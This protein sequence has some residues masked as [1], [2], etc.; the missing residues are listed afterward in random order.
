[1]GVI[2]SNLYVASINVAPT[3]LS[4]DTTYVALNNPPGSGVALKV[5][6]IAPQA[7]FSGTNAATRSFFAVQKTASVATGGAAITPTHVR[8]PI[9][10]SLAD[11]RFSNAGLTIVSSALNRFFF[12]AVPSQNAAV[13]GARR[14][15]SDDNPMLVAP[16]SALLL[17]AHGVTVVNG[18][19][20]SL[21]LLWAEE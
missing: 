5:M 14:P 2:Y 21:N 20:L 16:G 1:M 17:V 8:D 18:V 7:I 6:D 11:L 3:T 13:S 4:P 19:S 9:A 15:F 12:L 10:D